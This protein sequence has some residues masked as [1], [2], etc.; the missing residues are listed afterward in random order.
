MT[1]PAKRADWLEVV[2]T[3]LLAVAAVATAWSS[4]QAMRWNGEQAR[5]ASRTTALRIEAA[6][7][8][9]LSDSQTEVDVATF[10]Q[11]IDATANDDVE[12]QTFYE[13]RFRPEFAVAF[14]A[15]LE[16]APLI[17][18]GAP[19]TPFAMDDYATSASIETDRL[20]TESA[21]S[22]A[23]VSRN[24]QRASNYVLAVVLMSVAL[25][26]AGISTKLQA[27]RLR[28]FTLAVGCVV[29]LGTAAWIATFP[30]S[31]SV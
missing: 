7:A 9:A 14:D 31:I 22:S 4:Y 30:I 19:A 12:L 8:D 10:I 13:N 5:A 28:T 24:I 11:W 26:F 1:V 2:A 23:I 16:T 15:W 3:V 6:R 27:R 21:A 17:T 20:D 29:F 25:F 18:P